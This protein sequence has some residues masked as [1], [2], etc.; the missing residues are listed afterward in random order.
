MKTIKYPNAFCPYNITSDNKFIIARIYDID[1]C[2]RHC[3]TLINNHASES[4]LEDITR[5]ISDTFDVFMSNIAESVD[6]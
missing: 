2:L 1:G 5:R 4:Y 3:D 6:A